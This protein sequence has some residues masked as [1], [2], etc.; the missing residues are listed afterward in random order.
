MM[1]AIFIRNKIPFSNKSPEAFREMSHAARIDFSNRKTD[2]H[3]IGGITTRIK[4]KI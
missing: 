1:G 4:I 3:I 2:N